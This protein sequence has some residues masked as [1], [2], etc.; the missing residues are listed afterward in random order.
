LLTFYTVELSLRL[1]S[2]SPTPLL[3]LD[4]AAVLP[5]IAAPWVWPE[6]ADASARA[7]RP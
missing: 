6:G 3:G 7:K 5:S 4:L 2:C 1:A